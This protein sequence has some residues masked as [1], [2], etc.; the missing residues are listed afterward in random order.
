ERRPRRTRGGG[1]GV[2]VGSL[3]GCC[4]GREGGLNGLAGLDD[5]VACER[6]LRGHSRVDAP[7]LTELVTAANVNSATSRRDGPTCGRRRTPRA[8]R[9]SLTSRSRQGHTRTKGGVAKLPV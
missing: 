5:R 4:F 7:A 8:P 9:F 1:P 2:D 3:V 6:F